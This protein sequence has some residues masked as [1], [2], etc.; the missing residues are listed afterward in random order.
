MLS[1]LCFSKPFMW[2]WGTLKSKKLKSENSGCMLESPVELFKKIYI[3]VPW[4]YEK[5]VEPK[6]LRMESG[7]QY[8]YF[9]NI[10]KA[11]SCSQKKKH[12]NCPSHTV[13]TQVAPRPSPRRPLKS[14]KT[15]VELILNTSNLHVTDTLMPQDLLFPHLRIT[16]PH[17]LL[18]P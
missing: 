18:I 12:Y 7:Q 17:V 10:T 9:W 11:S 16:L 3:D 14:T 13:M 1:I 4:P 8:R 15:E 2:P 5:I 6:S